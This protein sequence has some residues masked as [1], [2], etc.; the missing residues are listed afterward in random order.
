[1]GAIRRIHVF[2]DGRQAKYVDLRA[3]G[4]DV[5]VA[6][7]TCDPENLL[8]DGVISQLSNAKVLFPEGVANTAR[9]S[10]PA[11]RDRKE[12]LLLTA[13]QLAAGILR[14][15]CKVLS[16]A[17]MFVVEKPNGKQ[18]AIWNGSSISEAAAVPPMP[19][20]L[21]NPSSF[22]EILVEPGERIYFSKRDASAYFDTLRAPEAL[23]PFFGR[24]C[25]TVLELMNCHGFVARRDQKL[26]GGSSR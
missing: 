26:C 18:R 23:Q 12:Y 14:L 7:A 8:S 20:R 6:G 21:A 17:D 13:R 1:M 5:P 10:G 16:C 19:P 24:P 25:V 3:D 4:V 9:A 22:L 2:Q 11:R 15:H